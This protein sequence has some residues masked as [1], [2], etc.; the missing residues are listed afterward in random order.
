MSIIPKK[1]RL[2][3]FWEGKEALAGWYSYVN[4]SPHLYGHIMLAFSDSSDLLHAPEGFEEALNKNIDFLL[5]WAEDHKAPDCLP[6][7]YRMNIAKEQFRVHIVPISKQE[8]EEASNSLSARFPEL[9][10]GGFL[11]Y[12]GKREHMAEYM[13]IKYRKSAGNGETERQLLSD[14]GIMTLVAQLR[15]I[16]SYNGNVE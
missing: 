13:E 5:K 16:A 15:E 4:R 14:S 3:V 6:V 11:Y 10:K 1:I 8:I 12:L 9:Q 2:Q 7:F